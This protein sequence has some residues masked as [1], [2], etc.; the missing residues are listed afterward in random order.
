[1]V[2]SYGSCT[3]KK[4]YRWFYHP[5]IL[6][7]CL[8]NKFSH[9]TIDME[10]CKYTIGVHRKAMKIPVLVGL[11]SLRIVFQVI[12]F[13]AYN[14]HSYLKETYAIILHQQSV[15]E[16]PL[17]RFIKKKKKSIGFSHLW[18]KQ[19]TLNTRRLR[20]AMLKQLE[21]KY[22]Q[23]WKKKKPVRTSSVFILQQNTD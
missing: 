10:F 9:E 6:L 5:F 4:N 11:G 16:I 1:M 2:Q 22:A 18:K 13:S 12:A 19:S 3:Q 20:Y 8:T 15:I 21:N 14:D 23:F 17:L 7:D